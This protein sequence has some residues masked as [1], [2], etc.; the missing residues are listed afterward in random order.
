M[1]VGAKKL[2]TSGLMLALNVIL[3]V[4][5]GIIDT[6]TLFFLAA[7]AFIIG[8]IVREFGLKYGASFFAGSIILSLILAPA[9]MYC[10]TYAGMAIYILLS[11]A[12]W[13][14]LVKKNINS[15]HLFTVIRALIFN[16]MFIPAII[17]APKL[18]YS[19]EINVIIMVG[20]IIAGQICLFIFEQAY[21]YFQ[22]NIWSK[23]RNKLM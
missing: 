17:I 15:K 13:K 9:K 20:L 1:H 16:V 19:G 7:A 21:C 5:S 23:Y 8:I 4:L 3:V 18:I 22:A 14:L 2:A 12:A 11:E 10:I 6:S